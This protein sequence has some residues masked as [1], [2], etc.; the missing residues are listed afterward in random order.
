MSCESPNDLVEFPVD[1]IADLEVPVVK[2]DI[3]IDPRAAAQHKISDP[4]STMLLGPNSLGISPFS[5]TSSIHGRSMEDPL[6]FLLE[7]GDITDENGDAYTAFSIKEADASH[8]SASYS[9]IEPSQVRVH[10]MLDASTFERCKTVSKHLREAG[11]L[12]EWPIYQARP[13]FFPDTDGNLG[14]QKFRERVYES[15]VQTAQR[16]EAP[17]SISQLGL[18]GQNITEMQF[19]VMYRAM[20]SNVRLGEVKHFN[21][22]KTFTHI[23]NAISSLQKRNPHHFTQWD[24]HHGQQ[25]DPRNPEDQKKYINVILPAIMGENLA[26]F[27]RANCHHKYLHENNWTLAGEIVDLD[28]VSASDLYPDESS[29][30]TTSSRMHDLVYGLSVLD[31]FIEDSFDWSDAERI[32]L[33]AYYTERLLDPNLSAS[34]PESVILDALT[35]T[36]FEEAVMRGDQPAIVQADAIVEDLRNIYAGIENKPR[37]SA[38]TELVAAIKGFEYF[39]AEAPELDD[40][41]EQ[42]QN[43]AASHGFKNEYWWGVFGPRV[44]TSEQLKLKAITWI[45]S[46]DLPKSA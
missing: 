24:V 39:L 25:L 40:F 15:L 27:H 7:Y 19:G 1:I 2:A 31:S 32:Y 29:V 38:A 23:A 41:K 9:P 20:L 6:H 11:V 46:V 22:G 10:G 42:V 26:R 34:D 13:A 30:V 44:M 5:K 37:N 14:L 36:S 21:E 3:Y 43:W 18:A 16:S 35:T 17:P 4:S 33:S 45:A 8:P 12:T 28:S